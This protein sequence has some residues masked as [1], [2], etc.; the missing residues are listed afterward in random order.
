MEV[1]L[2]PK[3]S[4]GLRLLE[5]G[6]T[7]MVIAFFAVFASG[8]VLRWSGE[9]Q[10]LKEVDIQKKAIQADPARVPT[11]PNGHVDFSLWPTKRVEG[12]L[13]SFQHSVPDPVAVLRLGN[14]GV[15]VCGGYPRRYIVHASYV[16]GGSARI[17]QSQST[18]LP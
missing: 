2:A 7:L 15:L 9:R 8:Y 3:N 16:S 11:I 12:Y 18:D 6:L 1:V 5:R 4:S 10:A 13:S 17:E 14:S